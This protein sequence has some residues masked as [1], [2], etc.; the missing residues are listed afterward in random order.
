MTFLSKYHFRPQDG[1]KSADVSLVLV[2]M[3]QRDDNHSKEHQ[4]LLGPELSL[5]DFIVSVQCSWIPKGSGAYQQEDPP[6]SSLASLGDQ[7]ESASHHFNVPQCAS[8]QR[9]VL[10]MVILSEGDVILME[11]LANSHIMRIMIFH[12]S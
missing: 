4:K 8:A 7:E 12:S 3:E 11:N 5:I 2:Q 6:I 9:N 1:P 10:K